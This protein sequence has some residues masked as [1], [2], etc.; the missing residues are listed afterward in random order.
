MNVLKIGGNEINDPSFLPRL[1]QAVMT[2]EQPVTVVH[3]GGQA[4]AGMQT[5]LGLEPRKIDG[6][7]VTDDASLQV[8]QMVLSGDVNKRVVQT[9]IAH[10]IPAVG[11]S[12]V[13]G[14]LLRCERKRYKD[15]DLG[16]VGNVVTVDRR[17][18]D[19]FTGEGFTPVISPV[20]LGLDGAIYNVNADEAA[21][22]IAAAY[23][24]TKAWFISNVAAVLDDQG[25][26]I[27]TIS[28]DDAGRLIE[29]GAIR[30][31]MI[32]KV[33]AALD[34]V[35]SGV[36]EVI[37]TN[38]DGLLTGAGTRFVA[39]QA[40]GDNSVKENRAPYHHQEGEVLDAKRRHS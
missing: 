40:M 32:P 12:G 7:R 21:S 27:K 18:L 34:L 30:D 5:R 35:A 1:A 22:A 14:G 9:L 8:T 29:S 4:I 19:L 38:I 31:G 36:S 15:Q 37:I 10:G 11:L 25:R 23:I 6:L 16:W 33:H 39:T 20:S 26:S 28:A 13:D 3:G 24:A 17:L 2:M